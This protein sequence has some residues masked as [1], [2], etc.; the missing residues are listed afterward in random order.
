MIRL[1]GLWPVGCALC[2]TPVAADEDVYDGRT[3]VSLATTFNE[4]LSIMPVSARPAEQTVARVWSRGTASARHYRLSL[5]AV[6]SRGVGH[7]IE[8]KAEK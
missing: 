3:T 7:Q 8:G 6:C 1:I 4:F 5:A 2:V